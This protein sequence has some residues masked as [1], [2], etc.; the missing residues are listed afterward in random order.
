MKF[1]DLTEKRFGRLQVISISNKRNGTRYW[2]CR[3]DCGK[4]KEIRG[5]VLRNGLT[6]S[7]GCL[8]RERRSAGLH[9]THGLSNKNRRLY[10]IWKGIKDRCTNK[11]TRDYHRYGGRR[12]T[13]YQ[14]WF[15]YKNFFQWAMTNGYADNL[16]IDR[17]NNDDGYFPKNC[18][19][20]TSQENT[21]NRGGRYAH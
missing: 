20:V 9:Q 8:Q 5:D 6:N 10:R 7:C 13:I 14:G 15:D 4:E 16:T 21:R 17:T 19:W 11:N 12:I 3:C 1:I 2:L 18:R